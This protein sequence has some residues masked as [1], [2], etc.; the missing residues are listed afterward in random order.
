MR[1]KSQRAAEIDGMSGVRVGAEGPS[2][3]G[4]PGS[5]LLFE[6][7]TS[8]FIPSSQSRICAIGSPDASISIV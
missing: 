2:H 3:R 1:I 6:R 4:S 5:F 7:L 8:L